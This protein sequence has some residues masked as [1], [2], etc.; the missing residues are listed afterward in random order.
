MA[1]SDDDRESAGQQKLG[2]SET[3]GR[4]PD[5]VVQWKYNPTGKATYYSND[6]DFVALLQQAMGEIEDAAGVDFQYM[7]PTAAPVLTLNDNMVVVGWADL[8]GATRP[9]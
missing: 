1:S 6:A 2:I 5:G 7:G 4:W 8:G 3:F 9:R